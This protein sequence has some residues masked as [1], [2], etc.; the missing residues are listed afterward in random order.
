MRIFSVPYSLRQAGDLWKQ[1]LDA[2]RQH[3]GETREGETVANLG[4]DDH[5]LTFPSSRILYRPHWKMSCNVSVLLSEPRGG[6]T[7][8]YRTLPFV[9]WRF[10]R[11]FAHEP[12][13]LGKLPNGRRLPFG[14]TWVETDMDHRSAKTR[15][16]SLIASTLRKLPGHRLRHRLAD[17]IKA[18]GQDADL[19]G[20]AFQPLERKADGL[21]P[22]R[23]SLIVENSREPGYF[24]EKLLDALFCDCVPIYWG[25]PDIG[26]YFDTA[27]MVVCQSEAELRAAVE[28]VTDADYERYM[29]FMPANRQKAL[30]YVDYEGNAAEIIRREGATRA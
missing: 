12:R 28:S 22:Y 17:W 20:Y 9:W 3:H 16:V 4:R 21:I 11:V 5:V 8:F 1:P 13:L 19:L 23:F 10:F 25:A 18:S 2:L 7:Q 26:R 6:H 15:R 29:A 30:A 24:T 14:T 27:G